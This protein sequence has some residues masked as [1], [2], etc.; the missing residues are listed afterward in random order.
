MFKY[1]YDNFSYIIV[2]L[3]Q[4]GSIVWIGGM[5]MFVFA[6][7]PSLRQIPNDKMMIRTSF[8]ILRRYFAF[9]FP[10]SIFLALSG[11]V[12]E[13]AK[14]YA[15]K[16]PTLG[17]VVGAKEAIWVLMFLNL[18]FAYYKLGDTKKRCMSDDV[19]LALDNLRLISHYLFVI[20]I[21]LGLC[22]VYLG[23]VLGR[24]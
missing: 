11:V 20:N 2:P 1:L 12:M 3:H 10:L 21:F 17:A 19:E 4:I 15:K 18:I 6:V 7:Y 13:F 22:A 5:I 14:D 9:L 8:R 23:L 24:V 16:D